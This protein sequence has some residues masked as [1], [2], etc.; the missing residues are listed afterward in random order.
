[1][2][3]DSDQSNT[4]FG[5]HSFQD[6]AEHPFIIYL[7]ILLLLST[8]TYIY[9]VEYDDVHHTKAPPKA[10]VFDTTLLI[11]YVLQSFCEHPR[12]P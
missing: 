7:S 10:I 11:P 5:D 6:T 8:T 4:G 1:M 3:M 2:I 9:V 12:P